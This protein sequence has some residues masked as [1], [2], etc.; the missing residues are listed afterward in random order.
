MDLHKFEASDRY[1]NDE[2]TKTIMLQLCEGVKFMHRSCV[3]HRDL[4]PANILIDPDTLV[5]KI[6]DFGLARV[7]DH[8]FAVQLST[9]SSRCSH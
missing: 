4:K 8:E 5:T 6:A 3:I 9:P 2:E 7:L 1:L